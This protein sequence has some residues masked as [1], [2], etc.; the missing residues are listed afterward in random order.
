[1]LDEFL[2]NRHP[3]DDDMLDLIEKAL[4]EGIIDGVTAALALSWLEAR[5][6]RVH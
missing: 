3:P 2:K 6:E 5:E 4:L 1:M